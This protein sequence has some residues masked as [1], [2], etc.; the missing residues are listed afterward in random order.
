VKPFCAF[1][2]ADAPLL[3]L[4]ER[5]SYVGG[6]GWVWATE[7]VDKQACARRQ[8]REAQSVEMQAELERTRERR[9]L[10]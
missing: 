5:R 4:T 7:C 1:C 3:G 9:V 8:A 2:N 10:A 6:T